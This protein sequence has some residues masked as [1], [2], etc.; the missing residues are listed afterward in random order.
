MNKKRV[1]FILMYVFALVLM[2]A[3]VICELFASKEK[4]FG[5]LDILAI[6]LVFIA[7]IIVL[8]PNICIQIRQK[9][10]ILQ[11]IQ[12][13]ANHPQQFIDYIF[14]DYVDHNLQLSLENIDK[15][16]LK[17][18][19]DYEKQIAIYYHTLFVH[20]SLMILVD[21]YFF[22]DKC[23]ILFDEGKIFEKEISYEGE[24]DTKDFYYRLS[25]E[26]TN[27]FDNCINNQR[28]SKH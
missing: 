25:L 20:Q 27:Q 23:L 16:K 10:M 5:L 18:I 7:A 13:H 4:A 14:K 21:V 22:H 8:V 2:V 26:I 15:Q 3:G 24:T 17:P 28:A 19:L 1:Y 12:E 11:T 9:K 6:S